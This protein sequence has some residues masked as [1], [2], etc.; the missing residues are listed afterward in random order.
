MCEVL[1]WEFAN[2]SLRA[3]QRICPQKLKVNDG[4]FRTIHVQGDSIAGQVFATLVCA[5]ALHKDMRAKYI[6][7]HGSA[8]VVSPTA[9][10]T[11]H[12]RPFYRN[13]Y[14]TSN[15][16]HVVHAG[17]WYYNQIH[18]ERAFESEVTDFLERSKY[19]KF[20]M[21][22]PSRQ[23]WT[24]TDGLSTR[25]ARL[26]CARSASTNRTWT[27]KQASYDDIVYTTFT[28]IVDSKKV[29]IWS[30]LRNVTRY[31]HPGTGLNHH[32]KHC[33]CLHFC[34]RKAWMTDVV[35]RVKYAY[36]ARKTF[37]Y[38]QFLR[39]F[40]SFKGLHFSMF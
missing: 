12:F 7:E 6:V 20:L 28:N 15:A 35:S 5:F 36:D 24:K 33:D 18:P 38:T 1:G 30:G 27:C 16:L 39:K 26:E 13:I 3:W 8:R 34:V 29:K 40:A 2:K 9:Y 4:H 17:P 19:R 32:V 31:D 10:L 37:R 14:I 25:E 22:A 23:H 11:F 21:V